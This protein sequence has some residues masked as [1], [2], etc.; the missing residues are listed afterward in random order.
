M[1]SCGCSMRK[2]KME[3][4]GGKRG[5]YHSMTQS[6]N[7]KGIGKKSLSITNTKPQASTIWVSFKGKEEKRKKVSC[8]CKI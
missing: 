6:N 2:T 5:I 7:I 3:S 1:S 4:K 8:K